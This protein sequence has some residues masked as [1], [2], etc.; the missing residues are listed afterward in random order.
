MQKETVNH[1]SLNSNGS[2]RCPEL[3]RT[4]HRE[5]A[6]VAFDLPSLRNGV[7][8]FPSQI[9]RAGLTASPTRRPR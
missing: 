2:Y 4:C 1:S 9:N 3:G 6:Y 7:R 5:G 8:V